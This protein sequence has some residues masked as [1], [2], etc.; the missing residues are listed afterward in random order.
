ME[1]KNNLFFIYSKEFDSFENKVDEI[2]KINRSDS[3]KLQNEI[4]EQ[5]DI[6]NS[7]N[8][9]ISLKSK[10]LFATKKL[11]FKILNFEKISVEKMKDFIEAL[12]I[13][14]NWVFFWSKNSNK[15]N[16]LPV[17]IK[18]ICNFQA[19]TDFS[20]K[21]KKS[22]IKK[23]FQEKE[24]LIE[25]VGLDYLVKIL[26]NT[27]S[28]VKNEL[29]KIEIYYSQKQKVLT[30]IDLKK[31]IF[32]QVEE[33]V[34][35]LVEQII[36]NNKQEIVREYMDLE[37]TGTTALY[38]TTILGTYLLT[39]KKVEILY[40]NGKNLKEISIILNKKI[41]FISKLLNLSRTVQN[42]HLLKLVKKLMRLEVFMKTQPWTEKTLL[43]SFLLI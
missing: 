11:I 18:K 4:Y 37:E 20:L 1:L 39:M 8:F 35:N 34:F 2:L 42:E 21:I 33:K 29:N 6:E 28:W 13:T 27:L 5:K 3:K 14:R 43:E 22:W 24:I 32:Y 26:P 25:A 40:K 41:F 16:D 9:I 10:N 17:E 23:F 19:V 38:L 36:Q 31:I 12:E 30:I 7:V 15:K